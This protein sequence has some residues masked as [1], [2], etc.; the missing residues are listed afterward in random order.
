MNYYKSIGIVKASGKIQLYYS[1]SMLD[2]W[3][4]VKE[5]LEYKDLS[6]KELAA[7]TQISYNTMQSWIT[8]DRLPDAEDAVKIAA[9]LDV[10]VEKLVTGE[11]IFSKKN[12]NEMNELLRDIRHLSSEDLKIVKMVIRRFITIAR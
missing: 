8:K 10:T 4:N 2:F 7:K 3:N 12:D 6:Q 9:A 5:E 11:E 1:E